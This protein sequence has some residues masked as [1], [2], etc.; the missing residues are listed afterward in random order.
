MLRLLPSNIIISDKLFKLDPGIFCRELPCNLRFPIVA[1]I[2]QGNDMLF[3]RV[4]V[5]YMS[6]ET[7]SFEDTQFCLG[8]VEP[9]LPCLGV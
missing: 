7:T 6:T 4:H 1:V 3:H 9:K 8:Y 2:F 5:W